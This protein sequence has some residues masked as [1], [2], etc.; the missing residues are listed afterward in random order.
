MCVVCVMY[1][2][3]KDSITLVFCYFW[4][5]EACVGMCVCVYV[6]VY[7]CVCVRVCLHV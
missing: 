5:L 4:V 7:V 6:C 1:I 3:I 2:P